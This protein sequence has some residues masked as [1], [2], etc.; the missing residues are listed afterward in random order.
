MS[1]L[2]TA[3]QAVRRA[4]LVTTGSNR[5][6]RKLI[7]TT[8]SVALLSAATRNVF[9]ALRLLLKSLLFTANHVIRDFVT[10]LELVTGAVPSKNM[11]PPPFAECVLHR[12]QSCTRFARN[13]S[14]PS[15]FPVAPKVHATLTKLIIS[16]AATIPI[17]T[18][19]TYTPLLFSMQRPCLIYNYIE[20]AQ[21]MNFFS[22][23][24]PASDIRAFA[25]YTHASCRQRKK[26]KESKD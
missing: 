19:T 7:P 3:R 10:Y 2:G 4:Q 21:Q 13:P 1:G 18:L 24:V 9:D 15:H 26:E 25:F 23:T 17:T 8:S 5:S 16:M 11:A 12:K 14:P 20:S 6:C 22:P